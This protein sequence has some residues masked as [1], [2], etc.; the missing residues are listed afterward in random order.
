MMKLL[1]VLMIAYAFADVDPDQ[2]HFENFITK[3]GKEYKNNA[4]KALRF[5][6]FKKNL[7]IMN[8]MKLRNIKH[9]V[10][11]TKHMDLSP[12]EFEDQL[13]GF[14]DENDTTQSVNNVGLTK[15]SS[16]LQLAI[17]GRSRSQA[18]I[19]PT[20]FDWRDSGAVSPIRDQQSCGGCWSFSTASN[21]ESMYL[22]KYKTQYD[23]S[24]QNMLNCD[25]LN[26]G[27]AGGS[28]VN[29]LKE[30]I[31]EGGATTEQAVPYL[32]TQTTCSTVLMPRPGVVKS[33]LKLGTTD[34][35]QIAL[36]LYQNGP[37]A[38]ALYANLL[39]YY[40]GGIFD[41]PN[42]S[43]AMN[44]AVNLVG[45][46]VDTDG[47]TVYWIVRNSWG[48]NWGENGYFRIARRKG[49]CGINK[50]VVYSIIP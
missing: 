5:A 7:G 48:L 20:R 39:Q 23:L 50:Y 31:S 37:L 15:I 33:Y 21:I 47:V 3:H 19:L 46:G 32:N 36:A 25:P 35:D 4:E 13:L 18:Y 17:R 41:D 26:K 8:A 38:V 16:F 1:T 9:Q 14:V 6:R 43:T 12:Q 24:E 27:C 45:Y 49:M 10:G 42:C 11:I 29:A 2:D 22:I 44:H 40:V 34:E 30:L 28:M